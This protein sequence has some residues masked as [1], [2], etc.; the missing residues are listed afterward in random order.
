MHK[1]ILYVVFALIL[2]V[3]IMF[4]PL[5]ALSYDGSF[6]NKSRLQREEAQK[7]FTSS[8]EKG[9]AA[10]ITLKRFASSLPYAMLIVVVG[11]A[12]ATAV[13]FTSK[14]KLL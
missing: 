1:H 9:V 11:L 7:S 12:A 14:R 6:I 10:N 3:I 8:N 13:S 2:G 5:V 4:L